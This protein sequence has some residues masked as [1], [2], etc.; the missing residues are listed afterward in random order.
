MREIKF[1]AWN[2]DTQK[3]VDSYINVEHGMSA[4]CGSPREYTSIWVYHNNI[5]ESL[6]PMQYTGLKDKNGVEIYEGDIVKQSGHWI[7]VIEY[8]PGKFMM[9]VTNHKKGVR[10]HN[11]F[12]SMEWHSDIDKDIEV[13]GNIYENPELLA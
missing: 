8:L 13:I 7:N 11:F 3:M 9:K 2:I 10:Y 1:R 4:N 6:I 12:N 5:I